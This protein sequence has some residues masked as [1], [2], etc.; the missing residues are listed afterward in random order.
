MASH[1]IGDYGASISQPV[2]VSWAWY[3]DYPTLPVWGLI[4]LLLI[5][6]KANRNR[7]AWLI[8]IPLGLVLLLWR[9]P[10]TLLALPDE[11]TETSG[12]FLVS[13]AMAWTVVWLLADRLATR[14][15]TLT[16]VVVWTVMWAVGVA[17]YHFY[18]ADPDG[19][20][21][22]VIGFGFFAAILP[23]GMLLSGYWC[24]KSYSRRRFRFWLFVW[25]LAPVAALMLSYAAFLTMVLEPGM[26]AMAAT[27]LGVM[28]LASV[29]YAAVLYLLNW[30]FLEL[31]FRSPLY[32]RRFEKLFHVETVSSP[33]SQELQLVDEPPISTDPTSQPVA[34]D[35]LLGRWQFYQDSAS[36]TV[37]IEFHADGTFTQTVTLNQGGIRYCPGG[38]WKLA[39]PW[40]HL[41]GYATSGG[42]S[43][44]SCDWR[45]ID[46]PAG[47]AL[48]G[49]DGPDASSSFRIKRV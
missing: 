43:G 9:M 16:L 42:Q 24:R 33:E 39:G 46:T 15:R 19:W 14:H 48:F 8:L 21:P 36:A 41:E 20:L 23:L 38:T 7:Q 4:V 11:V 17:S 40:V 25:M 5:V 6:P 47:L 22:S 26:L 30:P 18:N 2:V 13:A 37:T 3:Y 49:G 34:A 45:M 29:V 12:F 10:A 44:Q 32:R 31:A 1:E 28:A 35:D 27:M